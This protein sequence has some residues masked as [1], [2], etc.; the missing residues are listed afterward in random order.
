MGYNMLW[1]K[2]LFTWVETIDI[3]FMVKE[4]NQG[5]SLNSKDD[6]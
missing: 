6:Y 3:I 1:L 4:R 2:K 5:H